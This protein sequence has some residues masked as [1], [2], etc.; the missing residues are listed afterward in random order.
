MGLQCGNNIDI[1]RFLD[2]LEKCEAFGPLI[3]DESF[4]GLQTEI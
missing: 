1:C 2:G 4:L 3:M